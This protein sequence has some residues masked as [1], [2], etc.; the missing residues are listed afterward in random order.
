MSA[1]RLGGAVLT[2]NAATKPD[3]EAQTV[4]FWRF[5]HA[6]GFNLAWELGIKTT[7]LRAAPL[8]QCPASQLKRSQAQRI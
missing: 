3:P 5:E 7:G 2:P 6:M 4:A 8:S 1:L